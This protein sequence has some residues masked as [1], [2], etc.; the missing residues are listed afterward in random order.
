M[1]LNLRTEPSTE[2]RVE[3]VREES[4]LGRGSSKFKDKKQRVHG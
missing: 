4:V 3:S 2:V 1:R